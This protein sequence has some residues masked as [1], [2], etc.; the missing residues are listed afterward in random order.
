MGLILA[1][2]VPAFAELSTLAAGITKM[3]FSRFIYVIIL[4]NV[5]VAVVFSGLGAAA[6]SRGSST[7]AFFGVA[8]LPALLYFFYRKFTQQA[9]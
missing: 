6:L 7:L 9:R 2:P 4:S 8:L 3:R 1:R 5:G